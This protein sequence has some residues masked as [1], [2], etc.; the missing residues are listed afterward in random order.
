MATK[1]KIDKSGSRQR[2]LLSLLLKRSTSGD[3]FGLTLEQIVDQLLE[4]R[5]LPDGR[6]ERVLAYGGKGVDA[7]RQMFHRDRDDLANN[8]VEVIETMGRYT[9]DPTHVWVSGLSL[10][11]EENRLLLELRC[12]IGRPFGPNGLLQASPMER[13]TGSR[14]GAK[15][16]AFG[17]A[18]QQKRAVNF[19]FAKPGRW[20][21]KGVDTRTFV[22]LRFVVS[23][24][25]RYVVGY[26]VDKDDIRGFLMDRVLT[27]P[28]FASK[29]ANE[30]FEV[31]TA[32]VEK[33]KRWTPQEYQDAVKVDFTTSPA[34][35]NYV[36]TLYGAAV[37][38]VSEGTKGSKVSM[39]FE[40][41]DGAIQFFV[42]HATHVRSI[43]SRKFAGSL[44]AWLGGVNPDYHLEVSKLKLSTDFNVYDNALLETLSMISAILNS[45]G[46]YANELA[47][48]F[49]VP[50]EFVTENVTKAIM[51]RDPLDDAAYLVPVEFGDLEDESNPMYVPVM[52]AGSDSFGG[53]SPLTWTE[54]LDV[55]VMLSQIL[56]LGLTN[57]L[58]GLYESLRA[59]I[60]AATD[61]GVTVYS[62]S[63]PFIEHIEAAMGRQ[64]L[65][66]NYQ[67]DGSAEPTS[68]PVVPTEIQM[69]LGER[70]LRAIDISGD[71]P[72]YRTYNLSRVWGITPGDTYAG[73]IPQ[74][75]EGPWLD[76]MLSEASKVLVAVKERALPIW[77]NLPRAAIEPEVVE[78][79][80]IIEVLVASQGFLDRRLAMSGPFASVLRDGSPRAGVQLGKELITQLKL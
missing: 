1:H 18:K 32:N 45:D 59:K 36:S 24:N 62:P 29:E 76:K 7:Y 37:V 11:V 79:I 69:V 70:Y 78:G 54:V 48:R 30:K 56:A 23:G 55:Q 8:G 4:D 63:A 72:V 53:G 10:S 50:V 2:N 14:Y 75:T 44:K 31:G 3:R 17:L 40:S 21:R 67:S 57:E 38:A 26:D 61:V 34:F 49:S 47:E 33:A 16:A 73:T 19:E 12:S 65:N 46:L 58:A 6:V 71:E 28:K 43:G 77:E 39:N 80:H 22:P 74:D 5:E 9:I 51:A 60:H 41:E 52:N 68:R 13:A 25:R 35:A 20:R 66:L 27:V 64:V 42:T 15:A